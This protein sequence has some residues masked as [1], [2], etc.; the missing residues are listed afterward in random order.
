M[1]IRRAHPDDALAVAHVHVRSWQVG[2][3]GLIPQH[4][5][6]GLRPDQRASRY[7]FEQT[8]GGPVTLLAVDRTTILGFVTLGR[9]H[10]ADLPTD[11]E[12]WSL[13]V[14]PDQWGTGVGQSLITAAR[15]RLLNEGFNCANLWV[16]AEN[17]RARRFYEM[18]AWETDGVAR[19]EAL[20]GRVVDE[21]R[22]R[23]N[24]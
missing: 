16:L 13:Y 7:T 6:D 19:Q 3:R 5:L 18:D 24:L 2:Y 17:Y 22:Y 21:V 12:V 23:R 14:D 20:G 15:E 8:S 1:E 4:F 10:D 9:S 11:A